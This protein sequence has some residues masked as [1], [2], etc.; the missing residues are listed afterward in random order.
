MDLDKSGMSRA[1]DGLYGQAGLP[2]DFKMSFKA[3]RG[4]SIASGAELLYWCLFSPAFAA[5]TTAWSG[6]V[7]KGKS[8]GQ[9]DNL[10]R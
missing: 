10:V 3:E 6:V 5:G 2:S 1:V 7:I 9:F 4:C 8:L